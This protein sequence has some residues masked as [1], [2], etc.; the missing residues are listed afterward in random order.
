MATAATLQLG[1]ET[2]TF[3]ITTFILQGLAVTFEISLSARC[4][5]FRET[6]LSLL[7]SL[8]FNNCWGQRVKS[9]RVYAYFLDRMPCRV[10]VV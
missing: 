4:C 3:Q 10:A 9:A 5:T 7:M 2:C 6:C 1:F 8:S